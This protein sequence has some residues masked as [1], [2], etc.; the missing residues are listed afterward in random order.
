MVV[1]L[2]PR[3]TGGLPIRRRRSRTYAHA[4]REHQTRPIRLDEDD[5]GVLGA[6]VSHEPNARGWARSL[7]DPLDDTTDVRSSID[8]GMKQYVDES[9]ADAAHDASDGPK[10]ATDA[11]AKS[12]PAAAAATPLRNASCFRTLATKSPAMLL[13]LVLLFWLMS[14]PRVPVA[15]CADES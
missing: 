12:A 3:V 8:E 5:A 11:T 15:H 9:L 4:K 14:F 1:E 13:S 2:V 7:V 6:V 10:S